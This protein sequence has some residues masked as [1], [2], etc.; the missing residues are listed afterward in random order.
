MPL[1]NRGPLPQDMSDAAGVEVRERSDEPATP[2]VA[3]GATPIIR[4]DAQ[5]QQTQ[6]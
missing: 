6:P 2:S 1:E 3:N 5:P 4:N